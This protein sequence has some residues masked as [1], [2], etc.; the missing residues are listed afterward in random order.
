[1]NYSNRWDQ[2][3]REN[4]ISRKNSRFFSEI[5]SSCDWPTIALLLIS[6]EPQQ[7][8]LQVKPFLREIEFT[9]FLI[10]RNFSHFSDDLCTVQIPTSWRPAFLEFSTLQLFFDLYTG[11]WFQKI[12]RDFTICH[13]ILREFTKFHLFFSITSHFEPT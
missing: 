12:S 11:K 4:V 8:N 9:K 2:K 1:M 7:T 6:S 5:F 13:E 3:L 10:S